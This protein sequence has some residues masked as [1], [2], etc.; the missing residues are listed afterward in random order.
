M[1]KLFSRL[2]EGWRSRL[3]W[4]TRGAGLPLPQTLAGGAGLPRLVDAAGD[5]GFPLHL[6]NVARGAG[7][8]LVLP[9]TLDLWRH[10]N[11]L[12]RKFYRNHVL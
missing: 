9:Q 3:C 7:L 6:A 4:R 12:E 1:P 10:L 11:P 5:A 8:P 2:L